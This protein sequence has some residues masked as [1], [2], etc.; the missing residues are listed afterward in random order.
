MSVT[1]I[2]WTQATWNPV[3]GCDRVSP[4]CDHC[5]ALRMAARLKAMGSP[6][7]Q[8]D[9]RPARSG[10]GFAVAAHP[11]VFRL[12]LRWRAPR[13]IFVNSMSDLFHA[14]IDAGVIAAV[15]AT[16]ACTRR[17][18]YQVLTKR[19]GQAR[20][21]LSCPAFRDLVDQAVAQLP[22]AVHG[23]YDPTAWPLPNLWLG[24]SAEDDHW[25][26]VRIPVLLDTPAALRWV[27]LEPLLGPVDL[28]P[29]DWIP[30]EEHPGRGDCARWRPHLD[31]VVVGGESGP[32]A[33][34]CDPAWVRRLREACQA[35]GVA[36]HLKQ[37]GG[38]APGAGGAELDGRR[39]QEYPASGDPPRVAS[40]NRRQEIL[41]VRRVAPKWYRSRVL[42]VP[43]D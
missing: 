33:R 18:T 17:H 10:P 31:W 14:E 9:G 20:S 19:P 37:L 25:A 26:Q 22:E 13:R 43:H 15:F 11:E 3:T 41:T 6:K 21:L 32:R 30:A 1:G 4:G 7:Y 34:P 39:W 29:G 12:P 16:M 23:G 27:S 8:R 28:R 38:P 24:V 5:Y 36:F 2:S 35:G 40:A 42:D